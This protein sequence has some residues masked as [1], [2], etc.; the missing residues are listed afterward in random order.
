V[1]TPEEGTTKFVLSATGSAGVT[2]GSDISPLCGTG[3]RAGETGIT[4]VNAD[5]CSGALSANIASMQAINSAAS[6]GIM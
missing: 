4:S 5:V 6:G 2:T 3:V 1:S